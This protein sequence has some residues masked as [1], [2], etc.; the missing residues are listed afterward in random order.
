MDI[1]RNTTAKRITCFLKNNQIKSFTHDFESYATTE[2]GIKEVLFNF[3][4]AANKE[5]GGVICSAVVTE[6]TG[7]ILFALDLSKL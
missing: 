5:A 1:V 2:S 4:K 7:E 6:P 3:I